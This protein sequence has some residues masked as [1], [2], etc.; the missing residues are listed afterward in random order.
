MPTP[1]GPP[2]RTAREADTPTSMRFGPPSSWR[3]E[4][5]KRHYTTL[6]RHLQCL[7]SDSHEYSGPAPPEQ[8][9]PPEDPPAVGKWIGRKGKIKDLVAAAMCCFLP[10]GTAVGRFGTHILVAALD[11]STRSLPQSVAVHACREIRLMCQGKRPALMNKVRCAPHGSS[12]SVLEWIRR[13]RREEGLQRGDRLDGQ[14]SR[15][16]SILER[17]VEKRVRVRHAD[18]L[19][20]RHAH[21]LP[22]AVETEQSGVRVHRSY[23]A[24]ADGEIESAQ[25]YIDIEPSGPTLD[26]RSLQMQEYHA[27]GR[28]AGIVRSGMLSPCRWGV[29]SP[30]NVQRIVRELWA[31]VCGGS[32]VDTLL[33]ICL[34]TGRCPHELGGRRLRKSNAPPVDKKR[35]TAAAARPEGLCHTDQDFWLDTVLNLPGPGN[36][37]LHAS[38]LSVLPL[39]LPRALLS[40][41]QKGARHPAIGESIDL[42]MRELRGTIPQVTLARIRS[43]GYVWLYHAGHDRTVLDRLFGSHPDHAVPLRYEC[44]WAPRVTRAYVVWHGH[45]QRQLGSKNFGI[46]RWNDRYRIGSRRTPTQKAVR[47]GLANYRKFVRKTL[48]R[49]M[50]SPE[51]HNY[52]V[53]YTH[54]LLSFASG[55]RPSRQAFETL[56]DFCPDTNTYFI[57]DK[58]VG[59]SPSPRYVRVAPFAVSQL[60]HY[61]TY[62]SRLAM[63][64]R[65]DRQRDYVEAALNGAV[66][67]LFLLQ[68]GGGDPKPAHP[69]DISALTQKYLP[70]ESNWT[71]HFLRTALVDRKVGDEIVQ[72]FMGHGEMGRE[73]FSRFSALSIAD[74]GDVSDVIEAIANELEVRPLAFAPTDSTE[75]P[76]GRRIA[77]AFHHQE[78]RHKNEVVRASEFRAQKALGLDFMKSRLD[79]ACGEIEALRDPKRA[80]AWYARIIGELDEALPRTP[81]WYA[82][83]HRLAQKCGSLNDERGTA[84]PVRAP[85]RPAHVPVP[86]HDER[87]FASRKIALRAAGRF[88]EA[89]RE[90]RRFSDIPEPDLVSL[91]LF[92][93]AVFGALADPVPLLGFGRALQKGRISLKYAEPPGGGPMCWVEFTFATKRS[94][95]VVIDGVARCMRRFFPDGITL[96]LLAR[97]LANDSAQE[98]KYYRDTRDV[99]RQVRNSLKKLC[100]HTLLEPGLTLRH[101]L[102]GAAG[103]LASTPGVRI[104]HYL[105]EYACG[106]F[107][108]VSLPSPYFEA[109]LGAAVGAPRQTPAAAP[110]P[111]IEVP[112]E[113]MADV[114]TG[115]HMR[116]VLK[117]FSDVPKVL[118]AA[119]RDG[120]LSNLERLISEPHSPWL[121]LLA[122]WFQHLLT[123]RKLAPST[124][125]RYSNWISKAVL[126]EFDG[127][128][129]EALDPDSWSAGYES[130]LERTNARHPCA[131]AGR[132]R[133]FHTFLHRS[134]GLPETPTELLNVRRGVRVVRARVIPER[135]FVEFIRTLLA[136]IS[137]N[138]FD[139]GANWSY[140]AAVVAGVLGKWT[141]TGESFRGSFRLTGRSWPKG[142][143]R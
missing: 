103:A 35:L 47:D 36:P 74:L 21:S 60:K 119:W 102:K 10:A 98:V 31:G 111:G 90:P 123:A 135:H 85:P 82:A 11:G 131:V 126:F 122:S 106:N 48:R 17:F 87:N 107:D 38:A 41:L 96:M 43:A 80:E 92:S 37:E 1:D 116:I 3:T 134:R 73:P 19:H 52:Y 26:R 95:N 141:R 9:P 72:A 66:P 84:F 25:P 23:A 93:A 69:S 44:M 77:T 18:R 140:S 86:M 29:L 121:E 2:D 22:P 136:T 138:L 137:A 50:G 89:L 67:F 54:Q 100:G 49:A 97:H 8:A 46:Q 120:L 143:G 24:S 79:L 104:P 142:R 139:S 20:A 58:E 56:S 62:L 15:L 109:Y 7:L 55:L 101:F 108:S 118:K 68:D 76:T 81:A 42:R 91:I 39:A 5:P 27:R 4:L 129:P 57:R 6:S 110:G 63:H 53:A 113:K 128:S 30:L 34:L 88:L 12:T 32:Q 14:L 33:T 133:D 61:L 28:R 78:Q 75:I 65:D 40:C 124:V 127:L 125:T 16:E 13:Q 114:D 70:F 59:R 51:A 112:P 45:L 105:V 71:R 117:V 94:N 132:L 83:R 99:M 115:A 64:L 130:I